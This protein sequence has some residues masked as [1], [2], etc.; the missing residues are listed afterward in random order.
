VPISDGASASA[1]HA[2]RDF[3]RG[4]GIPRAG[5]AGVRRR[6]NAVIRTFVGMTAAKRSRYPRHAASIEVGG[7]A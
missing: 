6:A 7:S 4:L 1:G 5:G 2:P 3:A